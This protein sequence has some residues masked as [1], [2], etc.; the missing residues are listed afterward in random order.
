MF[1]EFVGEENV[2]FL[3]E[4][5]GYCMYCS[6]PNQCMFILYG[7]GRNG[8]TTFVNILINL[9]G[10]ENVSTVEL[11]DIL[12]NRFSSSRL[13]NKLANFSGEL[14]FDFIKNTGTIKQITGGDWISGE[15]KFKDAFDFKNHAKLIITTNDLP[16]TL[17]YSDGFYRRLNLTKFGNTF[18]RGKNDIKDID[19]TIPVKEYEG[20][21]HKALEALNS[22][23]KNDF[24]FTSQKT[25]KET[26]KEYE[27]LSNPLDAF[28]QEYTI[29]D[30]N[31]YIPLNS[32]KRDF[33]NFLEKNNRR[34]WSPVKINTTMKH[35]GFEPGFGRMDI[36]EDIKNVRVWQ[37]LKWKDSG[38]G[39]EEM[40]L[41][42]LTDLREGGESMELQL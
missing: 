36:G 5:A 41:S 33:L 35:K 24:N 30:L 13:E 15:R 1:I 11:K 39:L 2:D 32:F 29:E 42:D 12:N 20:F 23:I 17:D 16:I 31:A 27:A 28:L 34:K 22:L 26:I 9:L 19:N 21:A 6:Y 4:L 3:Y 8:K 38:R 40:S 7:S 18:D 37:G 10:K 14:D 25:L